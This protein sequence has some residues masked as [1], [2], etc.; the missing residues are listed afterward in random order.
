[1]HLKSAVAERGYQRTEV[2]GVPVYQQEQDTPGTP[3]HWLFIAG[4][5]NTEFISVTAGSAG[6]EAGGTLSPLTPLI[7][8]KTCCCSSS[9]APALTE[10]HTA[11]RP[12][13]PGYLRP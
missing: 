7:W 4:E 13:F 3:I 10:A 12:L 1:M 2:D 11:R 8:S 6:S 5:G 9:S